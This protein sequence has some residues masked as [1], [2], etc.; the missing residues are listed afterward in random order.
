MGEP[1]EEPIPFQPPLPGALLSQ[2][3]TPSLQWLQKERERVAPGLADPVTA[4]PRHGTPVTAE[5]GVPE[6]LHSEHCRVQTNTPTSVP[7]P[8]TEAGVGVVSWKVPLSCIFFSQQRPVR[9]DN[10]VVT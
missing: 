2:L 6:S 1:P 5:P 10:N 9:E 4:E 8:R 3:M 7:G